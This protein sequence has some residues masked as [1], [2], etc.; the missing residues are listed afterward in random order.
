MFSCEFCKIFKDTQ[1]LNWEFCEALSSYAAKFQ[2][3]SEWKFSI[4]RSLLPAHSTVTQ[5]PTV[6]FVYD[7]YGDRQRQIEQ[8]LEKIRME[9]Q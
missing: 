5:T 4:S 1:E 8:I 3:P 9:D 7:K 2:I 6:Q